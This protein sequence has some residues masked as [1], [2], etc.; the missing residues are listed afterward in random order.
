[1]RL[2][3]VVAV[4]V[5]LCVVPFW[6]ARS[7][8]P[9]VVVSRQPL[10]QERHLRNLRQLT[11]RGENAEAYFSLDDRQLIF[12]GHDGEEACDQIYIMD[13]AGG[14]SR[15]ASTGKGRTTCSYFFPAGD[16]ILYSSTHLVSDQC[17]PKPD[18]SRGYVWPLDDYDIFTANPDGSS[19]QQLSSTPGYDA[20]ATISRDGKKIVFTSLR[21]GDLD[22]YTMDIDGSNVQRL[23]Q[24]IGYDGGAFF[25]YDGKQIVYRAYHPSDPKE[26]DE[27]RSLLR[28]GLIRPTRLE[29]FVMNADGTGKRQITHN[30]AANFAPYFHPDGKRIIFSSNMADPR[31][32]NFDLYIINVDGTG[33]ERLT[34][35]D[36]FDGFPMF[37]SDGKLLVFGSNRFQAKSGDT[38]IFLADWVE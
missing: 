25:S 1:M 29:I 9:P 21:D 36:G 20:E 27:Y 10:A 28:D 11:F 18:Y 3:V 35:D 30:S 23:T 33:Q 31:G 24:D 4:S 14:T 5:V 17:P 16:R 8:Q 22:I 15:L 34:F 37:S 13:I 19:L 32:R 6:F 26:I 38:N 7:Q 2:T 12:Q